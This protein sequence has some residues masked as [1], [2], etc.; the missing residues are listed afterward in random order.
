MVTASF[1]GGENVVELESDDV[2]ELE[3][4]DCTLKNIKLYI[5][6]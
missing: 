2:L 1:G 4:D 5:L 6:K 3:S